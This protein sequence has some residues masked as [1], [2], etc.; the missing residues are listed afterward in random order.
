M[1]IFLSCVSVPTKPSGGKS[2]GS[3][4]AI[5]AGNKPSA[6]GKL[7]QATIGIRESISRQTVSPN[8]LLKVYNRFHLLFSIQGFYRDSISSSQSGHSFGF[9][10]I[11][12]N[13]ILGKISRIRVRFSHNITD[14]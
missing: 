13:L 10:I 2:N 4:V 7:E 12:F 9:P 6:L 3:L 11:Q 5:S 14:D 8:L 1:Q